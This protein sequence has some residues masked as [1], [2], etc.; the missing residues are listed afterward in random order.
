MLVDS[1]HGLAVPTATLCIDL[2]GYLKLD[3]LHLQTNTHTCS[4]L[5]QVQGAN[6]PSSPK[7]PCNI[8]AGITSL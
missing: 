1:S 2:Y 3:E 8:L 5:L 4:L 6:A 7:D